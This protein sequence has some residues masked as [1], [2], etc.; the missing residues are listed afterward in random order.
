MRDIRG[1]I[2]NGNILKCTTWYRKKF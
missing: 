1:W 2:D